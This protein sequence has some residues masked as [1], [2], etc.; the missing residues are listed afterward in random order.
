[1]TIDY[2]LFPNLGYPTYYIGESS[3]DPTADP[4]N[5]AIGVAV[6]T[7]SAAIL[8]TLVGGGAGIPVGKVALE[9]ALTTVLASIL[10][11]YV[12]KNNLDQDTNKFFYQKGK[13]YTG[14]YGIPV[15]YVESDINVDLRH[16]RNNKGQDWIPEINQAQDALLTMARRGLE[17]GKIS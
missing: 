11:L 12:K 5:V 8:A 6:A 16:G 3:V 7:I 10:R 1:M 14:T 2:W 4:S 15:F 9:T 17:K 13:F